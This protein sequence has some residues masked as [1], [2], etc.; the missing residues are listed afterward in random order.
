MCGLVEREKGRKVKD[1]AR[2]FI[3]SR[4]RGANYFLHKNGKKGEEGMVE[5]GGFLRQEEGG[6]EGLTVKKIT[7]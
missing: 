4:K 1:R 7:A 3:A 5:E 6:K 2:N